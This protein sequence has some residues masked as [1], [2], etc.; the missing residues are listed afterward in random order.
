MRYLFGGHRNKS[1]CW[2][3]VGIMRKT[4]GDVNKSLM[5]P[6]PEA[7]QRGGGVTDQKETNLRL[8]L[9]YFLFTACTEFAY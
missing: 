3:T 6:V 2:T 9:H 1:H 4:G 8:D 7:M 5:G